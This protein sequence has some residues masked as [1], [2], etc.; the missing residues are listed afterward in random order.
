MQLVQWVK[1]HSQAAYSEATMVAAAA[2]LGGTAMCE[3]LLSQ[4]CPWSKRACVT[5]ALHGHVSTLRW[6][7]ERG[8]PWEEHDM[9]LAAVT[10]PSAG[11]ELVLYLQLQGVQ[12]EHACLTGMLSRAGTHNKLA[13]AQWL[14]QQG[15]Q[16]T[17]VLERWPA[18]MRAWATAEGCTAPAH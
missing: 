15:A 16:W 10:A 18:K 5:S 1:E 13:A 2:E 11:A 7:H 9:V 3:I 4:Q 17:P 14:R 6:L 12:C 8:C